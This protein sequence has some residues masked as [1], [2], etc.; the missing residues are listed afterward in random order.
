MQGGVSPRGA[1]CF[2]AEA[3]MCQ[4]IKNAGGHPPALAG[5]KPPALGGPSIRGYR[6]LY[7]RSY[8]LGLRETFRPADSLPKN[9]NAGGIPRPLTALHKGTQPIYTTRRASD[10]S[11]NDAP[12]S[13][14]LRVDSAGL[15]DG[16]HELISVRNGTVSSM[17]VAVD[18][19]FVLS[20]GERRERVDA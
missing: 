6:Y 8:V 3:T 15:A 18:Y 5:G 4:R 1:P 20:R 9:K 19:T 2:Y 13:C 14:A 10:P 17:E 11:G 12:A 7:N 16:A